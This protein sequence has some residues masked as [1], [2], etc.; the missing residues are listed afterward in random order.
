LDCLLV[1]IF[2]F[3]QGS[4]ID[5][6]FLIKKRLKNYHKNVLKKKSQLFLLI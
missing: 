5:N 6:L 4:I 1:Q 2:I 3:N